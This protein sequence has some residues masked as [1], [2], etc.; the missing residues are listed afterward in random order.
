MIL[1]QNNSIYFFPSLVDKKIMALHLNYRSV[2]SLLFIATINPGI[3]QA[4]V[5]P[6][7]RYTHSEPE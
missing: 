1:C 3:V 5:I 7:G 6:D 4:Q 2:F